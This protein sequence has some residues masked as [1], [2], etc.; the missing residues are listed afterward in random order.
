MDSSVDSVP[1]RIFRHLELG[2]DAAA[3]SRRR[4]W[5]KIALAVLAATVT[6]AIVFFPVVFLSGVSMYL[7]TALALGVVLAFVSCILPGGHVGGSAVL[8]QIHP[9]GARQ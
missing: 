6:T 7:F 1:R 5:Q 4:W 8:L 9:V 2:E 3:G